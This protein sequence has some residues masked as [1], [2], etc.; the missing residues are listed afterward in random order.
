MDNFSFVT[1][2][3][4]VYGRDSELKTGSLLRVYGQRTLVVCNQHKHLLESGVFDRILNSMREAG[5]EP[6]FLT[7]IQPNPRL[8]KVREGIALCKKNGIDSVLAIGGGSLIDTA[9]AIAIGVPYD[10]DVW[11]F[12]CGKQMELQICLPVGV[13]STIA[14]AGSEGSGGTVITNEDGWYKRPFCHDLMRPR[15]AILNPELTFSVSPYQTACGSVDIIMHAL[16]RYFVNTPAVEL[17]DRY[18]EAT[19]RT[20]INNSLVAYHQPDNYDARGELLWASIWAHNDLL[21]AGR[22]GDYASHFIG[23]ELGA[24]F[25]IA[26]GATLS[27]IVLGWMRFVYLHDLPRFCQFAYRVFDIEP[28]FRSPEKTALAGIHALENY[29]K[30]LDMPVRLSDFGVKITDSDIVE[31]ASKCTESGNIGGFVSLS[32]EDVISIFNLMK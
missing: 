13:V 26:H 21:T 14:A 19:V 1:P 25:D 17:S 31:M 29:F 7:G 15:F 22:G 12:Y 20:V 9:K 24:K 30:K 3:L 27:V 32:R 18:C 8:S 2:T 28:D 4:Y 6:F 11:D 23:H 10:G 16:E 5:I